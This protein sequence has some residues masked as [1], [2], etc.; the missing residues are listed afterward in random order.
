MAHFILPAVMLASVTF[1]S[2]ALTVGGV[3]FTLS[4]VAEAAVASPVKTN[5]KPSYVAVLPP[6]KAAALD[7]ART[8]AVVVRRDPS[9][10]ADAVAQPAFTHSVAVESLRV[11]SGPRKTMPQL[12]ALKGGTRVNIIREE[13]G[14]VLVDAG[15]GKQGWVYAKLLRPVDVTEAALH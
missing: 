14:W 6:A 15:A 2:G 3:N 10:A 4:K 1:V 8:T 5:L 12:F 9:Q 13:R 11:R 7:I